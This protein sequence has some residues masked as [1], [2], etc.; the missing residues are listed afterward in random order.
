MTALARWR[1][2]GV[3]FIVLLAGVFA[4]LNSGE[5]VAIHLG[6]FVLYQV[7]L[8]VLIFFAFLLGMVM[9]FL[10]GLR[11]DLE[12]RRLLRRQEVELERERAWAAAPPR[13]PAPTEVLAESPPE[14]PPP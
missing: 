6:L 3:A 12:V 1:W 7:P 11:H 5:R 8:V 14:P 2:L 13:E 9:M 10:L 4:Y